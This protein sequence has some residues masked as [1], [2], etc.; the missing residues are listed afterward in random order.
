MIELVDPALTTDT[1][2][3]PTILDK[4]NGTP[5]PP[6][7]P[8]QWCQNGVLLLL[9]ASIIALGGM[10][11]NCSILY[12]PRLSEKNNGVTNLRSGVPYIFCRGGKVR[13]IQLLDYL[14][15]ASPESGLFSDWSRNKEVLRTEPWLVTFVAVWFPVKK[16]RE[17][18]N[19]DVWWGE[20]RERVLVSFK[21]FSSEF[22]SQ[23]F[24]RR[25]N[26]MYS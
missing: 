23:N 7:P 2:L 10:G 4:I 1:T 11:D 17:L 3:W 14:S 21:C 12:R 6:L 18:M 26:R 19:H 13:L 5:G 20:R 25:T 22:C 8:F 24:Q 16:S 15:V 9:R